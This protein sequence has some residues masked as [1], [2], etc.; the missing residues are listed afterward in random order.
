MV[1]IQQEGGFFIIRGK[2]NTF[3]NFQKRRKQKNANDAIFKINLNNSKINKFHNEKLK[4]YASKLK[5]FKIRIVKVKLKN[6]TTKILFTNI[7]N[8]L[9]NPKELK[10]LYGDKWTVEKNYDRLKKQIIH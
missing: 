5:R 10:E 2:T 4:K 3:S 1:K 7:P 9:A 8:N 6:N